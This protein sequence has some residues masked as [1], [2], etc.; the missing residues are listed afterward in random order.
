MP[1]HDHVT[2][3]II[4]YYHETNL[5]AGCQTTLYALRQRF[6]I[7][8]GR[9]EVRKIIR[10][11][12]QCFKVKPRTITY[13]TGNLPPARINKVRTFLNVG[14]D[15][16]GPFFIKEKKFRNTKRIKVYIAAFVC[17]AS[18]AVHLEVVSDLTSQ[19]FVD[20][21]KRFISR[22]GIPINIYSDNVSNFC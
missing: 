21:L 17:M 1:A 19:A 14:V 13:T 15:Y 20:A 3:L 6:W 10:N 9:N 8:N 16:C 18:K 22:R 5:H 11:C 12:V 4:R 7:I 2:N